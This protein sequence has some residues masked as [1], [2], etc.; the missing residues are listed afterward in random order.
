MEA[1]KFSFKFSRQTQKNLVGSSKYAYFRH[2]QF[3]QVYP[4]VVVE[5]HSQ[6]KLKKNFTEN[7][8]NFFWQIFFAIFFADLKKTFYENT[9]RSV[10]Y[11]EYY[12]NSSTKINP[13]HRFCCQMT[14]GWEIPWPNQFVKSPIF[15]HQ[16][17]SH[18]TLQT[19]NRSINK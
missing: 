16:T 15:S 1:G 8:Q 2:P 11:G 4:K 14:K 6:K 19:Q 17:N 12:K 13:N 10:A 5:P 18:P 9:E 7:F 3:L